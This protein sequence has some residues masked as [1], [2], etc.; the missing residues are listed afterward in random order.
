MQLILCSLLASYTLR[1]SLHNF[2][3][4]FCLCLLSLFPLKHFFY[5]STLKPNYFLF[6]ELHAWVLWLHHSHP[7]LSTPA[8]SVPLLHHRFMNS[9]LIIID[10]P[11][12]DFCLD[13]LS[14]C[15]TFHL[16]R[17]FYKHLAQ[18][19]K[20]LDKYSSGVS[21]P[22]SHRSLLT[23]QAFSFQFP[24]LIS[25]SSN[26]LLQSSSGFSLISLVVP[27]GKRV[28]S[29]DLNIA[30][31]QQFPSFCLQLELSSAPHSCFTCLL[32]CYRHLQPH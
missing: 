19:S 27:L 12:F 15:C 5:N 14:I 7:S 3:E 13:R 10:N 29:K 9:S 30:I 18:W 28:P 23:S 26:W 8:S 4:W 1:F 17:V 32:V 31:G 21:E 16:Y 25:L 22:A 20:F 2:H 11:T 6:W 24:T